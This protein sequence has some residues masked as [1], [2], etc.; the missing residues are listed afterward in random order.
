MA[1]ASASTSRAVLVT[2][3]A[4]YIGAHTAKALAERGLR[5]I[6]FDNLSSGYRAAVQW[7]E[8]V[9]GDIRDGRALRQAIADYGVT[10]AIHFASLI[11]VGRSVTRPDLF[12]EHNV[13]GTATLLN[14]LVDYGVQ[15]LVFSSSAAVYGDQS[16]SSPLETLTEASPKDPA[17]PYG[18]TKLA[19]ERMIAS[20]ARA[21]G[22]SSV[23]LRYFNAAGADP[24]GL[25]GEAHQP[26]T[27]LIPLAITAALGQR[28]PLTVFGTD[29][30]TPD[31]SCLR[32]YIHVVDLAAAH[33]AALE[34]VLP[35]G[36]FEA[37][38]VGAGR[39]RSVLEVIGAV[40]RVLGRPTPF[41]I[42]GRRPGDPPSLVADPARAQ[43]LLNWRAQ[44][45][46]M[47]EIVRDAAAWHRAPRYHAETLGQAIPAQ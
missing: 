45:S 32:D 34:V 26:E 1:D 36:A 20:Y 39:G 37:V 24:C 35:A 7:G 40:D 33:L 41:V 8:F 5:P 19:C 2:G 46:S 22:F 30:D 25:I 12:Y 23:A 18:D 14:A 3:G 38:N 21:F 9:H 16:G 4:G 43:E 17:S 27:H 6:V 28:G 10:A 47:D 44:H 31:G 42:G 15:R 13:G 11:E 29:F